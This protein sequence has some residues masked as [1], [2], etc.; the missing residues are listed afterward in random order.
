MTD[1]SI[2]TTRKVKTDW[3]NFY[4]HIDFDPKGRPIG[5]SISSPLKEPNNAIN[6]LVRSLSAGLDHALKGEGDG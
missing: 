6:T 4:V 2:C 5:G 3:G 1:R